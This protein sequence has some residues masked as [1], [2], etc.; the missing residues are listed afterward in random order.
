VYQ[1]NLPQFSVNQPQQLAAPSPVD[2]K[3]PLL[4]AEN[5][6]EGA[7]SPKKFKSDMFL[8]LSDAGS[9][10]IAHRTSSPTNPNWNSWSTP[11]PNN[12]AQIYNKTVGLS[13][14]LLK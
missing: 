14:L 7:N 3:P 5:N 8:T 12:C 11:S 6:Q 2:I 10:A 9:K 13:E 4:A 1:Y